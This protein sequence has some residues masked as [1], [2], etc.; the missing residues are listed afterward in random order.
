M[1]LREVEEELPG[2]AFMKEALQKVAN[3]QE[4]T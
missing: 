2:I 3:P 4:M 1:V